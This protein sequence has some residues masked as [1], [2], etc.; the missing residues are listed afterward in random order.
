MSGSNKAGATSDPQDFGWAIR[1]MKEDCNV[2]RRWWANDVYLNAV[3][4]ED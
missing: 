1:Q 3:N 2:R 4:A